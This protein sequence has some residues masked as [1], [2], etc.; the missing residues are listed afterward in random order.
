[1]QVLRLKNY[2]L[3][4]G[5]QYTGVPEMETLLYFSINKLDCANCIV[6]S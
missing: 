6:R 5:A 4:S 3:I 1:M 2:P